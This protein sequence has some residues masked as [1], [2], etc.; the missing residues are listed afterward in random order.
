MGKRYIVALR[1]KEQ[2]YSNISRPRVDG[3]LDKCFYD[4]FGQGNGQY[5]Q[6]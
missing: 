1:E 3:A 2:Q 6:M 5:F 4:E